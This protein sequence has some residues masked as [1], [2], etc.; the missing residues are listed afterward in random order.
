MNTD[1][2]QDRLYKTFCTLPPSAEYIEAFSAFD[3]PLQRISTNID[4]ARVNANATFEDPIVDWFESHA[5]EGMSTLTFS[6][7]C[8][9]YLGDNVVY[10]RRRVISSRGP[11]H[12]RGR[13]RDH[14]T[15]S[16]THPSWSHQSTEVSTSCFHARWRQ[17]LH[18]LIH[19]PCTS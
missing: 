15:H 1:F 11:R 19:L 5:P 4:E 14:G 18:P 13:Y 3:N 6:T 2:I 10:N 17:G 8:F 12:S 16:C 9:G 7:P